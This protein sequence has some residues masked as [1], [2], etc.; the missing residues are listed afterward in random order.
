MI[1]ETFIRHIF[2]NMLKE[3]RRTRLIP[4]DAN[5]HKLIHTNSTT[6]DDEYILMGTN[7]TQVLF[8]SIPKLTSGGCSSMCEQAVI[9][10]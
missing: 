5:V 10:L 9:D 2:C 1:D 3:I 8:S 7:F 4:T 6:M